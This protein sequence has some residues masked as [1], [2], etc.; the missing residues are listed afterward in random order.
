ML[1]WTR[2]KEHR[3]LIQD[4]PRKRRLQV[5]PRID[6]QVLR[7]LIMECAYADH[8]RNIA[9]VAIS[10]E[11]RLRT[12]R[13]DFAAKLSTLEQQNLIVLRKTTDGHRKALQEHIASCTRCHTS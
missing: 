10:H 1:G 11:L 3:G 13:R 9:L 12:K 6:Q 2:F 8:L 4:D 7:G 5:P